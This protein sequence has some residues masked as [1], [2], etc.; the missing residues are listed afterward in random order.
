MTLDGS[1][2]YRGGM[3]ADALVDAGHDVTWWTSTFDHS[4]KRHRHPTHH[5]VELRPGLT[6]RMLHG[7]AYR[8]N[9]SLARIRHNHSVSRILA[10][11]WR[12]TPP[13]LDL[14]FV[15]IPLHELAKEAL[16]FGRKHGTPVVLDVRDPW[17][18]GYLQLVPPIFRPLVRAGLVMA[19]RR[20][21]ANFR[22]ADAVVA[23]SL[24]YLT[25]AQQLGQ[26]QD[27]HWDAVFPIGYPEESLL[28]AAKER[29]T[30]GPSGAF[31][32]AFVGTFGAGYDLETVISAA[33]LLARTDPRVHFV[34]AG[35][36]D[37]RDS[38]IRLA[39][40]ESNVEMPGW[41]SQDDVSSL[42]EQAAA[43]LVAYRSDAIQTLPNKPF[44]YWAAGLPIISSL[45]GEL[46]TLIETE[47]VGISYLSG[48]AESLAAAIRRLAN[49]GDDRRLMAQRALSLF[50]ERFAASKVYPH[51]VRHLE[52]VARSAISVKEPERPV[53]IRSSDLGVERKRHDPS[54]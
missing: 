18:E 35:D 22:S 44:E 47:G 12:R 6:V 41:I 8:R 13:D 34:L 36:G 29:R 49:H 15:C 38:L 23:V 31:L 32:V 51:L 45:S 1:R 42:L 27:N 3:L 39:A 25:W 7:P 48:D 20:A 43:G 46:E 30:F 21:R 2:P 9:V 52:G 33:K 40:G 53:D 16:G 17:P 37:S 4:H 10:S 11:E 50:Q 28:P 5:T 19:F 26:R 14:L 24:S 54:R